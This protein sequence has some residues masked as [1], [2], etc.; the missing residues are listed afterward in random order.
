MKIKLHSQ[1]DHF[2]NCLP[3]G[4][5]FDLELWND[6]KIWTYLAKFPQVEKGSALLIEPRPLQAA[7]YTLVETNY[8]K[9]NHIFTHDSQLLA[10]LP[11]AEP[12]LFWNNYELNDEPKTKDI[13]FICGKKRMCSIHIERMKLAKVLKDEI[14]V[15]GDWNNG[16]RVNTHDAYAPYKFAVVIENY[17]DDDWFTEKILNAFA[18]KTI[19]IYF[20]ARNISKYFNDFGIIQ[21]NN[22]WDIPETIRHIKEIGIDF[23]YNV[24][25]PAI[26]D[27]F[28]EV[29]KYKN[30]ENWFVQH[31]E[32]GRT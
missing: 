7:T 10:I 2:P 19:P 22:L 6:G 8:E 3:D 5:D 29:Q 23:S 17:M 21:V 27:N 16:P 28:R 12:I 26:E 31:Y 15:L 20:G 25:K 1:Y 9:F 13:S 18:N 11:N 24:R 30:F 32:E 14:D 4:S